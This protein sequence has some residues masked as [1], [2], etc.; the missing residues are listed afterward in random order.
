MTSTAYLQMK[1]A[2]LA[3]PGNI[4]VKLINLRGLGY[5]TNFR[6]FVG[7]GNQLLLNPLN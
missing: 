7:D 4:G 5:I 6:L 3:V 1:S 2:T